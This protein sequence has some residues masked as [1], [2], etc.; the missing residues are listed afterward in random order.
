MTTRPYHLIFLL[1]LQIEVLKKKN[2]LYK[3]NYMSAFVRS[4]FDYQWHD[5][6]QQGG[7]FSV[8][9]FFFRARTDFEFLLD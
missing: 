2:S 1:H 8:I 6:H 7:N 4:P 5:N 3:I 9:S